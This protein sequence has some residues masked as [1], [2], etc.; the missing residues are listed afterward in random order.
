MRG[1]AGQKQSSE[2]HRLSDEA[3]QRRDAL[4]NRW[5]GD[6]AVGGF[7]VES[8]L[9]L[10]PE[11]FIRP[12]IDVLVER[13]LQVVAAAVQRTHRAQCEAAFMVGVDQLRRDW[14]RL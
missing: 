5:A 9:Q 2:P 3:A 1:V 6:E 11:S 7:R 13:A 10:V 8:S 12:L 14:R 4:F